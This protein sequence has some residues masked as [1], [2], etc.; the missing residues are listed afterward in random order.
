MKI[1]LSLLKKIIPTLPTGSAMDTS[2]WQ[3]RLPLSGLEVGGV[4]KQGDGLDTVVVAKILSF[5]KHPDAD[6]LNV[7]QVS[8]GA[9]SETLQIVCGAPN[10]R[11]NMYVALATEGSVLPG[12]FKIKRS[13]IRNVESCGMLC[14][15]AELALDAEGDGILDLPLTD[16]ELGKPLFDAMKWREE[17]WEIELT[18]D[19]GDCLSHLGMAREI[20]RWESWKLSYPEFENIWEGA[21]KETSIIDVDVRAADACPYYSLQVFDGLN[22]TK[23]PAELVRALGALGIRSHNVG[24]DLTNLIMMELGQPMHAFDADKIVGSKVVVRFAK[25]G[26]KIKTLDGIERVLTPEDLVIA[27]LEKPIAIAGVMGSEDSA[28]GETTKRIALESAA[29][30]AVT[31]RKTVQRHKIHSD[32]SHRFERGVDPMTIRPGAGRYAMLLRQMAGARRRGLFVEIGN[33]EELCAKHSLNFDL[34]EYKSIIG[35]EISAEEARTLLGSVGIESQLKSPNVLTVVVPTHRFDLAREVDLVEEVSR[36]AGFEK[37]PSRFPKLDVAD[38]GLTSKLYRELRLLRQRAVDAGLQEVMPY[39]FVSDRELSW[40]LKPSAVKLENP[41]SSDWTYMRPNV[42]FGLLNA[43]TRHCAAQEY[44]AQVFDCGQVFSVPEAGYQDA[45]G[46]SLG[47]QH[48][49]HVGWALMGDRSDS[50]WSF[51]KASSE[52]KESYDFFDAKGY[53]ETFFESWSVIQPRWGGVQVIPLWQALESDLFKNQIPSWIP[54]KLLH[55]GRSALFYWPGKGGGEIKGFVGEVLSN[56]RSDILNLPKGLNLGLVLAE[57]RVFGDLL[58]ESAR[59]AAEA[60]KPIVSPMSKAAAPSKFPASERDLSMVFD[61]TK[62]NR[63]I[64]KCITKSAGGALK[65]LQCVDLFVLP[66]RS[67]SLSYRLSFQLSDRSLTEAEVSAWMGSV[68]Q[69]LEKEMGARMR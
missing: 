17:I 15:A 36:L 41:L 22:S 16:A 59:S 37:I 5:E 11:Q 28:V 10:V 53:A 49:I 63:D 23:S 45:F 30:D 50:H 58:V 21:T 47:A 62:I 12:D 8:R 48:S 68:Q 69:A 64:E 40:L 43:L 6:K 9:D 34:R 66:D 26:E 35:A 2:V 61:A 19:R 44:R 57:F 20:A 29:F 38:V 1:S 3:K 39:S 7:C 31:I 4:T 42:S 33:L 56:L 27:D 14:S 52:R 51:D 65:S 60:G 13:K 24:A 32:A 46:R 18:P 54:V 55:P 67:R 25:A